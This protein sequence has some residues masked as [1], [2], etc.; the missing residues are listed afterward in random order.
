MRTEGIRKEANVRYWFG[1]VVMDFVLFF[2][3]ATIL[4]GTHFRFRS[5]QRNSLG[6]DQT[7]SN[8]ACNWAG[9]IGN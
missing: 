1:T 3:L 5:L 8:G 9:V 7:I 2:N 6:D 4:E